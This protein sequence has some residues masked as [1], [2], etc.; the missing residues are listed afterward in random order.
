VSDWITPPWRRHRVPGKSWQ[1]LAR[2]RG[3]GLRDGTWAPVLFVDGR[4]VTALLME[5]R[6]AGIPAYCARVSPGWHIGHRPGTWC[7][8]VGYSAYERAEERLA[9]VMPLLVRSLGGGTAAA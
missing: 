2:Q 1:R 3:N 6:R 8:W 5:L 4:I 9:E 7:L